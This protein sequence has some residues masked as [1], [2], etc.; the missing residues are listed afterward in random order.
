M[1]FLGDSVMNR[2]LST[3]YVGGAWGRGQAKG[4]LTEELLHSV[5]SPG[6]SKARLAPRAQ[7]VRDWAMP[8]GEMVAEESQLCQPELSILWLSFDR[9]LESQ[10][11]G[12]AQFFLE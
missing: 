12:P 9:I 5:S 10:W 8:E 3:E 1:D 2:R 11:G 7:Q 4:P 6:T